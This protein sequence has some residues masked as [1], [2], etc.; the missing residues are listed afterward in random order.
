ML[1]QK[2]VV[3]VDPEIIVRQDAATKRVVEPA[4]VTR[5][6]VWIVIV[7]VHRF[8]DSHGGL[9]KEWRTEL[10]ATGPHM[11]STEVLVRNGTPWLV[12]SHQGMKGQIGRDNVLFHV[13]PWTQPPL[14]VHELAISEIAVSHVY[15]EPPDSGARE[16]RLSFVP[17]SVGVGDDYIH[18]ASKAWR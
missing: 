17:N 13:D 11:G 6:M 4:P 15:S 7:D 2:L 12:T 14:C 10:H 8:I 1:Q 5:W 18:S 9:S 16:S 3:D